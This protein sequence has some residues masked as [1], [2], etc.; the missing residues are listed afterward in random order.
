MGELVNL[1]EF[2]ESSLSDPLRQLRK[3]ISEQVGSFNNQY[4]RDKIKGLGWDVGN[5]QAISNVLNLLGIKE[6]EIGDHNYSMSSVDFNVP[7]AKEEVMRMIG[8]FY[9][10]TDRNLLELPEIVSV[11]N[12][13]EDKEYED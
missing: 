7:G 1:Q 8:D 9:Y 4:L 6:L 12:S 13:I 3:I 10:L 11:L 5:E 2:R